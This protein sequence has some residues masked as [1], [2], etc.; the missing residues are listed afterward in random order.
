[1]WCDFSKTLIFDNIYN[2]S[3]LILLTL[4]NILTKFLK[5]YFFKTMIK[6]CVLIYLEFKETLLHFTDG[7]STWHF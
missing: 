1:M 4:K 5:N 2:I 7:Y 6:M 3:K